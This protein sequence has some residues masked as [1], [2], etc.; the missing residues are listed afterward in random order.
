MSRNNTLTWTLVVKLVPTPS[1]AARPAALRT[2]RTNSPSENAEKHK[3]PWPLTHRCNNYRRD[4]QATS[5]KIHVRVKGIID[6]LLD[7]VSSPDGR[8]RLHNAH[9]PTKPIFLTPPYI[10]HYQGVRKP[11]LRFLR[12]ITVDGMYFP[13]PY[14]FKCELDAFD[15]TRYDA[16]RAMRFVLLLETN[17]PSLTHCR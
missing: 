9:T 15:F 2:E 4:L 13:K 1:L 16:T 14:L 7:V 6:K 11:I 3:L 12:H 10:L 5:M 8:P 17:M